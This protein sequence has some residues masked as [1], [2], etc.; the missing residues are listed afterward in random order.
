MFINVELIF[1]AMTIKIFR[2]WCPSCKK[3]TDV[4]GA[5]EKCPN[6]GMMMPIPP[7]EKFGYPAPPAPGPI[8]PFG[9]PVP[10]PAGLKP[11]HE[12]IIEILD[13]IERKIDELSEK[14]K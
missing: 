1:N 4:S 6:C 7:H 14:I 10:P 9:M 2:K 12:D 5:E 8:P 3:L 13:R 11:Q